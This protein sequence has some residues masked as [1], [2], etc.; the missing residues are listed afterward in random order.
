MVDDACRR[1]AARSRD[2]ATWLTHVAHV[3]VKHQDVDTYT[4]AEV[5]TILASITDDRLGHAWEFGALRAT[6]R[7]GSGS[8]MD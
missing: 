7:G 1:P 4:E 5:Q 6:T 8:P 3:A 2:G